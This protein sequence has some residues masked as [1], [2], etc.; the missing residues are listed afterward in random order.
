MVRARSVPCRQALFKN[1]EPF[2]RCGDSI[3]HGIAAGQTIEPRMAR[4]T[5]LRVF[6][7]RA[8]DPA[9]RMRDARTA[10]ARQIA[11]CISRRLTKASLPA[12]GRHYHRD[13]ATILCACQQMERRMARDFAFGQFIEKLEGQIISAATAMEATA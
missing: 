3:R 9:G 2:M 12:L 1:P 4:A 13:H 6:M 7:A 5:A 8:K 10:M 11:I